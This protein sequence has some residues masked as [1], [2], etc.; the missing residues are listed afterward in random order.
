MQADTTSANIEKPNIVSH[1]EWLA[2]RRQLLRREKEVTHLNDRLSAARRAMP[3]EKVDKAYT[4]EGPEGKRSLADLF[5]GR[6]QLI[7]YHFMFGPDWSEGCP[8]CSFLADHFDGAN[9]HLPHHDVTLVAVSRAP[10]SRLAA[11]KQRLGWHFNW[12]SSQDSDFN[13]DYHVSASPAETDAGKQDYNFDVMDYQHDEMPGVS[14]FFKDADG[15]IFHTYS[16]YAR[17][18]DILL[19]THNFL[20]LTP[21]GRAEKSTMDWVRHHDRYQDQPENGPGC[22]GGGN[23]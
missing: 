7:V 8:S 2:A 22:C 18:L 12:Y 10:W 1:E 9:L 14:V 21:R 13:F 3:W 4:F 20:D 16:A 19:G 5:E 23:A 17:G 15:H 6:S 11:F